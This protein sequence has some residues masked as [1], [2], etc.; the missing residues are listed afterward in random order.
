MLRTSI[1]ALF[2]LGLSAAAGACGADFSALSER[3]DPGSSSGAAPTGTGGAGGGINTS[4]NGGGAPSPLDYSGL[5]GTGC[6]PSADPASSVCGMS[7]AGGAGGMA[8]DGGMGGAPTPAGELD[9]KLAYD[10]D[11]TVVAG[12]CVDSDDK[13]EDMPCFSSS[14]C[15][16]G[17]GCDASGLCRAY[18]CGDVEACPAET[19]CSPQPMAEQDA[20]GAT[21]PPLIPVC[22]PADECT[23]LAEN[24][25]CEDGLTC[26]IVRQ[27]GTT[28]CVEP[29]SG[30]AGDPCPCAEDHACQITTG[31]CIQLCVLGE[32]DAC[33]D[34]DFTCQS[35]N[36]GSD[37]GYC[38][39]I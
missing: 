14:D 32:P 17:L 39:E 20:V 18:C 11:S 3:A 28:A 26:T 8:G 36:T 13:S 4:F 2:V 19:Y 9:C 5:C 29:G 24:D 34:Q 10:G 27:D 7:G 1:I 12:A 38:I 16:P 37:V 15:G 25:L 22:V 33:D 23:P 31:T 30:E 21:E 6:Q 35:S